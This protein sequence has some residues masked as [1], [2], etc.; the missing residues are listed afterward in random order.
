MAFIIIICVILFLALV[1][2]LVIN[3]IEPS[4]RLSLKEKI[5]VIKVEGVIKDSDAILSRLTKFSKDPRV[6]AIILRID[7]PGGGVGPSQEIYREIR[8][9]TKQKKVIASLGSVAASGGYYIASAADVIVANPGTITGSIGVIMQF[10]QLEDLLKKMGVKLEVLK[11][12]EFKDT[13]SFHRTFTEQDR[14]IIN[15]VLFDVK[16]QFVDAVADGRKMS[17]AEILKVADGRIF[18]GSQAKELGLVDHLGNFR[19]AV[20]ITKEIAGIKGD[21]T[22]LYPKEKELN[23]L[24]LLLRSSV[25]SFIDGL[26]ESTTTQPEYRMDG[27]FQ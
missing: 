8:K 4:S 18:T 21:P 19:D 2:A 22:L 10:F 13:G 24:D 15:S 14:S 5:G 11:T 6:R 7:S 25:S 17:K 27:P 1:M 12:G 26:R 9:I 3:V 23:L 20:T 16:N